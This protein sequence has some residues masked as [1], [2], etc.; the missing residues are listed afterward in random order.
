MRALG[1]RQ[2]SCLESFVRHNGWPGGWYFENNSTTIRI[3][4]SFVARGL[5]TRTV[6]PGRTPD[7]QHVIFKPTKAAIEMVRGK[8]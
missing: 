3:L 1:K 4:D 2:Q 5:A 7:T 8:K 6:K